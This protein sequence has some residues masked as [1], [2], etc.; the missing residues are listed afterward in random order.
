MFLL[1]VKWVLAAQHEYIILI[2]VMMKGKDFL[3]FQTALD[4]DIFELL[5]TMEGCQS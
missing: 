4:S 1:D 2:S 5:D 3:P